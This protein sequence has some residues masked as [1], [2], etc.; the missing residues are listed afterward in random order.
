MK[1]C[2]EVLHFMNALMFKTIRITKEELENFEIVRDFLLKEINWHGL[3][4]S[5]LCKLMDII[6][7]LHLKYI[8][9]H[10][11]NGDEFINNFK[12]IFITLYNQKYDIYECNE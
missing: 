5:N 8:E 3:D 9:H 4:K 7:D 10:P 6:D 2:N 12:N 11:E 1:T